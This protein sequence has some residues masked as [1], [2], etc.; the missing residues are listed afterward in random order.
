MHKLIALYEKPADEAQFRSHLEKVHLPLVAKFPGLRAM[1][2]GFDVVNPDTSSYF[3]V[4]ECE[5]D[6][7]EDMHAALASP[8]SQAAADDVPNYASA[9]VT[10]LTYAVA[11][12]V[13]CERQFGKATR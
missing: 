8:E 1:R 4:V 13:D 10:I 3:A 6:S 2:H 12:E 7:A 5:F 9:G 11:E